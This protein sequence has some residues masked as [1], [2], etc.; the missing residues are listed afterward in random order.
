[1]Q[2]IF[3]SDLHS[4]LNEVVQQEQEN[5]R[6]NVNEY[7]PKNTKAVNRILRRFN[8]IINA[9]LFDLYFVN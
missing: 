8:Y 5:K 9:Y 1:M 3:I 4:W 2:F 6:V 7:E